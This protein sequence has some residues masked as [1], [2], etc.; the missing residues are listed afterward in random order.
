[1]RFCRTGHAPSEASAIDALEVAFPPGSTIGSTPLL[2]NS[3][4][5]FACRLP[6]YIRRRGNTARDTAVSPGVDGVGTD[7]GDRKHHVVLVMTPPF[8]APVRTPG[9]PASASPCRSTSSATCCRS[10]S[11]AKVTRGRIGVR[12]TN[13]P[14]EALDEFGLSEQRGALVE[15]VEPKGPAARAW[16]HATASSGFSP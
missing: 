4:V 3:F 5:L 9:T 14:P 7:E 1:M 12:V 2:G 8:S 13:V 11:R 16:S 15:S 6:R 10:C